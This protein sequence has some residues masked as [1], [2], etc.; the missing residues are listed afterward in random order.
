M[1]AAR[2]PL[3][4]S[5]PSFTFPNCVLFC[6]GNATDT[7]FSFSRCAVVNQDRNLATVYGSIIVFPELS[8]KYAIIGL[9]Q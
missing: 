6:S 4:P 3:A 7:I 1:R 5:T 9:P 8:V 2:G